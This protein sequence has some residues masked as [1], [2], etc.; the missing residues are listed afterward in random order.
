M[1]KAAKIAGDMMIG[2]FLFKHLLSY[3][4]Q[5]N[6]ITESQNEISARALNR[7]IT[8][9]NILLYQ[10]GVFSIMQQ[11]TRKLQFCHLPQL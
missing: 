10:E 1:E 3:A 4:L 11:R 8:V 9:C 5:T 2:S 7:C 6:Y